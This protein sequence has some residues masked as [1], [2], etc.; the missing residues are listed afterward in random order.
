M[1]IMPDKQKIGVEK[2]SKKKNKLNINNLFKNN[3]K[4]WESSQFDSFVCNCPVSPTPFIEEA[5]FSSLYI[6]ACF[7]LD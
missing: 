3:Y 2:E 4:V 1:S 7:V 6:L 5:V